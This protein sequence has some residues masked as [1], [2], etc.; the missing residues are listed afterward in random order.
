M[1][2]LTILIP[3]RV[4]SIVRLEN[5]LA[6]VRYLSQNFEA[7][8]VILEANK[9]DNK[10]LSSMLPNS[11]KH[12]F[13]EDRDPIFYRTR[14]INKMALNVTTD[15]LAV[16]D[17][18][19]VI[20]PKQVEKAMDALRTNCCDIAYPY[21]GRFL[22]TSNLI[23][24]MYLENGD[25]AILD[26]FCNMMTAPYGDNMRG[27][28]FLANTQKYREAGMENLNF[29]GWGPE[30]WERY[31]RW[32]N[33]EYRIQTIH[34]V[35]FHLSHPRDINGNHNSLQQKIRCYYAK[36]ITCFS[37]TQE[38]MQRKGQKL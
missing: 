20:P 16:W 31:E 19:V 3:I 36:D 6:V 7:S 8:I 5:L 25:I 34:G 23:R 21:D 10:V 28:A 30:D 35:L 26:K 24:E 33:L 22:D 2:D 13:V 1:K 15:Y 9:Y 12:I 38:I 37:S 4:E 14:Y 18:D 11:V 32:K 27:G 29:Y 17:A